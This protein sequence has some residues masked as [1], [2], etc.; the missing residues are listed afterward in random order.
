MTTPV[1]P[2]WQGHPAW[3]QVQRV[4]TML[5]LGSAVYVALVALWIVVMVSLGISWR[6]LLEHPRMLVS[7][8]ML[9]VMAPISLIADVIVGR[10]LRERRPWALV[11]GLALF[12]LD[13]MS[14][15]FLPMTIIGLINLASTS[16]RKAFDEPST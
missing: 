14:V 7:G 1:P 6:D 12:A 2:A 13:G 16:V 10:G 5:H 8:L 3:P 15:L 9:V 11:A 4:I